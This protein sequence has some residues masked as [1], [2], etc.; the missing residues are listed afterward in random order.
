MESKGN[1]RA[2]IRLT[3]GK[4]FLIPLVVFIASTGIAGLAFTLSSTLT[5][6]AFVDERLYLFGTFAQLLMDLPVAFLLFRSRWAWLGGKGDRRVGVAIG[7][8]GAVF[9]ASTRFLRSGHLTFME[10]V[11]AFG[12]G[13]MLP[14][15][16]NI[17]ASVLTILAYGPG[18]ALFQ[19]YLILAFDEAAGNPDR[20]LSPGVVANALLWGL[21]HLAAVTRYGWPSVVNALFMFMVG[22][23]TG[24]MFKKTRSAAAPLVFWTLING[25]SV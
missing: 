2:L 3:L 12:Q 10:Q 1:E 24:V 23:A 7:F 8:I 21:G 9:V 13:S 19:V 17:I 11:P 18:E 5:P 16:W 25:T 4:R 14:I 15:P 22:L 6:S 20:L